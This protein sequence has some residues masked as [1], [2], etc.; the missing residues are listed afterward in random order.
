MRS[1][2][3]TFHT[4]D[5]E[6]IFCGTPK[7]RRPCGICRLH[8]HRQLGLIEMERKTLGRYERDVGCLRVW[9][10]SRSLQGPLL[11][12]AGRRPV[13]MS[14]DSR[15]Y[16]QMS[17]SIYYAGRICGEFF[18]VPCGMHHGSRHSVHIPWKQSLCVCAI[19]KARDNI[20]ELQDR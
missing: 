1:S 14:C 2:I 12:S 11:P 6:V 13:T 16:D 19:L 7:V 17:I 10:R 18:R 4:L 9:M 8:R 20:F 15:N 3:Y 5:L